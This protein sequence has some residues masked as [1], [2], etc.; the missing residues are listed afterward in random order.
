MQEKDLRAIENFKQLVLQKVKVLE[1]RVFGSRAR[2][3]ATEES[4]LDILVVVDRLDHLA[5]KYISECA[6]EAGFREDVVIM[7]VAVSMD[8]VKNSPLRE[9]VFIKTVYREGVA[10]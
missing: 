5:E 4:D 1:L 2:G 7:P 3:D 8:A 10:I 6:W 9:S